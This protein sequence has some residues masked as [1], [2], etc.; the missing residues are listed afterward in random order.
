MDQEWDAR[1]EKWRNGI[2]KDTASKADF[3]D[4]LL[5]KLH[6]YDVYRSSDH[7][8]WELFQDDFKDFTNTTFERA[9]TFLELQRL[10]AYLRCGGVYVKQ[11]QI[12]QSLVNVLEQE[13]MDQW[14]DVDI[15][16]D[17]GI[18]D[19]LLMGPITS[20]FLTLHGYGDGTYAPRAL[21]AELTVDV[22]TT[23]PPAL[24][25]ASFRQESIPLHL[26]HKELPEERQ[27]R[28]QKRAQNPKRRSQPTTKYSPQHTTC[29][30][31]NENFSS[32]NALFRHLKLCKS[33]RSRACSVVSSR[34]SA[35]SVASAPSVSSKVSRAS[36]TSS[37]SSATSVSSTSA[38]TSIEKVQLKILSQ[39]YVIRSQDLSFLRK[40][41]PLYGLPQ[42]RQLRKT[43]AAS[44]TKSTA[45]YRQLPHPLKSTATVSTA[46]P[47]PPV[48]PYTPGAQESTVDVPEAEPVESPPVTVE[49]SAPGTLES[50]VDTPEA[51]PAD[52]MET[53]P[54]E[55][56]STLLKL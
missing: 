40:N 8:L 28:R 1:I 11:S 7:N 32:R 53:P 38:I 26:Q 10:R 27:E 46:V 55:S 43:T 37:A 22:S 30:H 44:P 50:T 51:L 54:V 23:P 39:L 19:D 31:C 9:Y 41:D 17:G 47:P 33:S 16:E 15:L 52:V 56:T 29:R 4:Y 35:S 34:S 24:P 25:F 48:E 42:N 13:A 36:S 3:T 49:S 45:T 20:L 5:T 21:P 12:T 14:N 18:R 2:P 6:E